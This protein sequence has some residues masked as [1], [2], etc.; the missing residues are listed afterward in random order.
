MFIT[1]QDLIVSKATLDQHYQP[2]IF[3]M[4]YSFKTVIK[5]NVNLT[6]SSLLI[7]GMM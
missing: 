4:K 1:E 6:C 5:M 3:L 7:N 2:F